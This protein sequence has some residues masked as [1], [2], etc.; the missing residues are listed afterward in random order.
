[1]QWY[2]FDTFIEKKLISPSEKKPQQNVPKNDL[3]KRGWEDF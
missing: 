2:K 1:M 3:K